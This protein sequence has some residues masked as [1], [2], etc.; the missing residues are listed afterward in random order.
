MV[1]E[2]MAIPGT[3]GQEAAVAAYITARLREAGA[4]ASAIR[5][6]NAHKKTPL[7]G[8]VGNLV[9]QLPGTLPGGVRTFLPC[10][11]GGRGGHPA[12]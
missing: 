5:T 12:C 7:R 9:F 11:L 1:M 10:R 6:D 4:S 3:S 8:E 2:L